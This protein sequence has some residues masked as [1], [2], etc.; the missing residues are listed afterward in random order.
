MK[1]LL[2]KESGIV[3][4]SDIITSGNQV[5]QFVGLAVNLD[6]NIGRQVRFK[7]PSCPYE[8][9]LFTIIGHQMAW[10]YSGGAEGV[11]NYKMIPAYRVVGKDDSFGK[12]AQYYAIDFVS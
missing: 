11:G 9:Q 3:L 2:S 7:N 12:P 4:D 6:E 8:N 1:H 5:T 10:G